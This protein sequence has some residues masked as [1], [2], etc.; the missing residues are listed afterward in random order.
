MYTALL[1][2]WMRWPVKSPEL[3]FMPESMSGRMP[4]RLRERYFRKV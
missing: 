2:V 4:T 3:V 1:S